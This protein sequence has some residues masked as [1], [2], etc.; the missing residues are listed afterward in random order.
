MADLTK[1]IFK[2]AR[3]KAETTTSL[4]RSILEAETAAREKKTA[5]LKKLRL[6]K[7]ARDAAALAGQPELARK[8]EEKKK[9]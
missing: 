6:E 5:R 1:G 8:G 4:S 3:D 2:P 7:E 9:L